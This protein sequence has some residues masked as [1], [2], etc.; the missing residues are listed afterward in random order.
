[1]DEV[2]G[3]KDGLEGASCVTTLLSGQASV[4]RDNLK[5][6]IEIGGF[7]FY[8]SAGLMFRAN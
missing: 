4:R 1:M 5:K 7:N 8:T 2:V 3:E 6:I